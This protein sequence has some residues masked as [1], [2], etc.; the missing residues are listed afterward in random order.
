MEKLPRCRTS[1]QIAIQPTGRSNRRL[2]CYL[3]KNQQ[4]T[5]R[6]SIDRCRCLAVDAG[7]P[8]PVERHPLREGSSGPNQALANNPVCTSPWG[9]NSAHLLTSAAQVSKVFTRLD[10]VLVLPAS[11][12]LSP[13]E[14]LARDANLDPLTLIKATQRDIA[15][16]KSHKRFASVPRVQCFLARG[17]K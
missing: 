8:G 16:K 11:H 12:L 13:R 4:N 14:C 1:G 15:G 6:A 17:K 10:H 9:Y 3:S 7:V 5:N 2:A